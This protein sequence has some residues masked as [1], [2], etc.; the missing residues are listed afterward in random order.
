MSA[1]IPI[2]IEKVGSGTPPPSRRPRRSF[3]DWIEWAGNMLPDP[4]VLFVIALL[5]TWCASVYLSRIEFTDIDPR[6]LIPSASGETSPQPIRVKNQ[7]TGEALALFISRMVKN[8]TEFPPLGVVLVAMLGVGVAEHVGMVGA[9]LKWLMSF[10]P[11]SMLTPML[12]CVALLSHVAGDTG[13]VLVI[14]LGGVMFAVAGRHPLAGIAAAFAGVS[15]AF[16][17][18]FVPSTLDPLLQGFTQSAAQIIDPTRTVNP[19]CNWWFMAAS[20]GL[21]IVMG[22]ILTDWYIEPRLAKIGWTKSE[23]DESLLTPLTH[24]EAQRA[25]RCPDNDGSWNWTV[26][27]RLL[28]S[29]FTIARPRNS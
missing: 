21:L 25:D 26:D 22:W 5:I 14:P 4:A 23:Q 9:L 6:T 17:A 3:L 15:G 20:S 2:P 27:R 29:K 12:L 7:L 11:K 1:P 16:S 24:R 10:T 28:A 19:L 13:Y 18:S 8:F